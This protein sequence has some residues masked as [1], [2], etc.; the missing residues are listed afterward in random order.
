MIE[1]CVF[2][3]DIIESHTFFKRIFLVSGALFCLYQLGE[4]QNTNIAM[5]NKEY[6]AARVEL[7]QLRRKV[8]ENAAK[9]PVIADELQVRANS[10]API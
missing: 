4:K 7:D 10:Y 3:P 9:N 5:L 1:T 6:R 2:Y 8:S